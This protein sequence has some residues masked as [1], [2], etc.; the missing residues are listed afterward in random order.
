MACKL[1]S[2]GFLY[3]LALHNIL[4]LSSHIAWCNI[5]KKIY[6]I[7]RPNNKNV[8]SVALFYLRSDMK[9]NNI[10]TGKSLYQKS[11]YNIIWSM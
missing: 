8:F 6:S 9:L 2:H 10:L 5:K 11:D 4:Y 1:I 7:F 3:R